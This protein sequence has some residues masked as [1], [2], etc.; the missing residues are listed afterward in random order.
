MVSQDLVNVALIA[1]IVLIALVDLGANIINVIPY[2]G[3]VAETTSEGL[4]ELA[5]IVTTVFL[6]FNNQDPER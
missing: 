3:S 2:A 1:V 5:Q 6:V 4:L